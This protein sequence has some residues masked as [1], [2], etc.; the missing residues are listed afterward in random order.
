MYCVERDVV[1]IPLDLPHVAPSEEA[2]RWACQRRCLENPWCR[3]WAYWKEGGHCHLQGENAKRQS[4]GFGFESGPPE[5]LPALTVT[6]TTAPISNN[7]L[8]V[9]EG[10][11]WEP[12]LGTLG[13]YT[14]TVEENT[15]L[16]QSRCSRYN[17]CA[18]FALDTTTGMCRLAGSFA[19]PMPALPTWVSGPPRCDGT[20]YEELSD[21]LVRKD[22]V[23]EV[24]TERRQK[25]VRIRGI[26]LQQ[27]TEVTLLSWTTTAVAVIG[28]LSLVLLA[29]RTR[30][31]QRQTELGGIDRG[32]FTLMDVNGDDAHCPSNV[33]VVR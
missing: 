26:G 4:Y 31:T 12:L 5:C 28:C 25:L 8:C 21:L 6:S 7:L 15:A 32:A 22:Q 11:F 17:G 20:V 27:N 3:H 19:T 16:C 14:G 1:W 23:S 10:I 24:G 30:A 9:K 13:F 29:V 33:Q 18:H 2:D